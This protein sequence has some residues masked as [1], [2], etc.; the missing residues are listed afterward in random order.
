M[1][2]RCLLVLDQANQNPSACGWG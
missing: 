2:S 1:S